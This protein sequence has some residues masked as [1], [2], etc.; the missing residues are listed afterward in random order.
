MEHYTISPRKVFSLKYFT[1]IW[2]YRNLLLVLGI[3]DFKVRYTKTW[4]GFAWAL[5]NPLI[6]LLVLTFVFGK[7]APTNTQE[8]PHFIFTLTGLSPW[9]LF[10]SYLSDSSTSMHGAQ[11]MI[12]KIYFPKILIPLSKMVTCGI[13]FFIFFFIVL[14]TINILGYQQNT[15]YDFLF[16]FSLITFFA[17]LTF[18]IWLSALAARFKDFHYITPVILRVGLFLTPIGYSVN[19]VPVQWQALYFLNP[20]SSITEAFRWSILGGET[21]FFPLVLTSLIL[22]VLFIL[23]ILF[24]HRLEAEIADII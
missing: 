23:G 18:G 4:L 16:L 22:F 8:F 20:M 19:E 12:K 15:Q 10:S 11:N 6:T 24:F 3:R 2:R 13:D 14:A 1:E 5:L 17:S 9:L 21:S 7:I